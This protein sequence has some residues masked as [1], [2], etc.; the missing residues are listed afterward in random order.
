MLPLLLAEAAAD[1]LTYER[2][3]ELTAHNPAR[4]FDLPE[5]GTLAPAT[6]AD[7]VVVDPDEARPIRGAALHSKADWTPF[8][9]R[10]GV[11]PELTV[12]RG[13]VVYEDGA[14]GPPVGRNV[15]APRSV[16]S[17]G[18]EGGDERGR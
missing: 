12:V 10:E 9:G 15:R 1:R 6:D 13:H 11:F 8:E 17:R 5:K 7:L 4:L 3:V 14:F 2:V 16:G 18:R